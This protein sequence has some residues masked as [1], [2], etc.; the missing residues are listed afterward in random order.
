[1][2]PVSIPMAQKN[3]NGEVREYRVVP[4]IFEDMR[5][6]IVAK[7]LG[8]DLR[9]RFMKL[10]KRVSDAKSRTPAIEMSSW[11]AV[12]VAE[13][14][15]NWYGVLVELGQQPDL[16]AVNTFKVFGDVFEE[17]AKAMLKHGDTQKD[18]A[19][20]GSESSS[21]VFED[22]ES[23][24]E[25]AGIPPIGGS[26]DRIEEGE[27]GKNVHGGDGVGTLGEVSSDTRSET[28]SRDSV[29]ND[30]PSQGN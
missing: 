6:K 16:A 7:R 9:K 12:F 13:Q 28:D 5:F 25:E 27:D 22:A 10:Y 17:Q 4:L 1:M 11:L 14:L 15:M 8:T 26:G 18:N 30:T 21:D 2:Q 24:S 19:A 3:K 23:A 20:A 29:D